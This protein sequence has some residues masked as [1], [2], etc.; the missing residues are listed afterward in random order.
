MVLSLFVSQK[1]D[2]LGCL[3]GFVLKYCHFNDLSKTPRVP[4]PKTSIPK[5]VAPK[6]AKT[7][8]PKTPRQANHAP[9]KRFGQN[10]L[11]DTHIIAQI[12]D[13]IGLKH[14]DNVLE[15]GPGLG[16]LTEPLL[17]KVCAMSVIELDRDLAAQLR[18]NIGAN[19]HNDFTIINDNALNVDY[20]QLNA[21]LGRGK[22]RIVG[23]LPYNISTPIL[24]YLLEFCAVIEDMHFMLQKEV[25]ERITAEVGSKAYGRLSV[26]MQYYCQ[27][28]YLLTVPNHAFHPPPKV[29]SAVFRLSPHNPKPFCAKDDKLFACVVRECFNHRRKTLR[30]IFRANELLPSLEDSDFE[31]IGIN[32]QARPETLSVAQ[33]VALS[34]WVWTHKEQG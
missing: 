25:V 9:K 30:A 18:I 1:A 10:F 17:A 27:S 4:M 15:I 33:F 13:S 5:T 24:F 12:V 23:N 11:H 6:N 7:P 26:M 29:T 34:D 3:G 20:E 28:C 31:H 16:A 19:S 22:F 14:D 21:K 8:I 2:L 32:P